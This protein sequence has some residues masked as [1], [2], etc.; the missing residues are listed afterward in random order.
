MQP[1]KPKKGTLTDALASVIYYDNNYYVYQP[2]GLEDFDIISKSSRLAWKIS[3]QMDT[4]YQNE[5]KKGEYLKFGRVT[6][7]VKETS[8]D[9]ILEFIE[10]SEGK[11]DF[12][13]TSEGAVLA[14]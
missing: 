5:F 8:N 3:G 4:M 11:Q 13:N 1:K 10:D 9:P 7:Y 14:A 2:V 12:D 6:F